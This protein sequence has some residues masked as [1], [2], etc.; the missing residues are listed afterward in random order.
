MKP[1]VVASGFELLEGPVWHP[2]L[3]LMF[4]DADKGGAY[5]LDLN[6]RITT[7]FEHRRGIGGM[8]WHEN[9]GLVISGRNIAYKGPAATGTVVLF[10]KDPAN[11]IV[12]FND[13]TTDGIGR[14]YAG[15]LGFLPTETEFSG[16]G[17][18]SKGAPLFLIE[19]D[20]SSRQVWPDI[21]LTNGMGFSPDFKLLYH[22]DSGD[23]T[24]YV[25]D[26]ATDGSLHRRRPFARTSEGLPDGLAVAIDG[27]VWVVVAHAGQ[28]RV[29]EPDGVLR[30]QIEFPI[31]MVTSLCFGGPDMVDVYVM[32]GSEG[33]G[34]TDA[35]TIFHLP[36]SVPGIAVTPARVRLPAT[37]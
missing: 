17:G 24:V 5:R 33:S 4:A 14:V 18:P 32:S 11:G 6:G 27:S 10:E 9:D 23:R 28:V 2:T 29:F 12:G 35:G 30:T 8:A 21:K 22:A 26:V 7:V 16:I 15:A 36:S 37:G 25:Y 34:R 19:I 1:N 31:P 13:I 20:G 3:G